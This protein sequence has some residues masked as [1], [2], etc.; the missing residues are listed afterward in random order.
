[1]KHV[2][3]FTWDKK[4]LKFEVGSLA[5]FADAAV[6]VEYG[7]NTGLATVVVAD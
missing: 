1:M 4:T 5:Y 3:E 6:R 7:D 2:K